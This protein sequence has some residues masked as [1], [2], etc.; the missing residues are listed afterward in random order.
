M[1]AGMDLVQRLGVLCAR[2]ERRLGAFAQKKGVLAV[3]VYEFVRFG[4]KQAWACLVGGVMLALLVGSYLFYPEDAL[5][6]RYDALTV[7][8]L[9]V[10]LALLATGLETREEAA[11]IF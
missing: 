4:L 3:F 7:A 10:Q 9:L 2:H 11:V 1:G 6:A 8:A 5:V